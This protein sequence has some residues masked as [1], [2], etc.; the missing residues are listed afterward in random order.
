MKEKKPTSGKISVHGNGVGV[1][2]PEDI[3][4]RAREVAM[5]DERNPEEFTDADWSQAREELMGVENNDPP[6]ENDNT[7][8][9]EKEWEITPDNRGRRVPRPGI[10]EDEETVGEQLV[11][12]GREEAARDQMIDA[13]REELEQ[14][15][16][17][18]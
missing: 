18:T 6:E 3:E 11:N 15:G 10:E 14:E 16:G 13:R 1:A 5:I 17:I 12:D 4:R 7:I 8:K 9:L 2:S